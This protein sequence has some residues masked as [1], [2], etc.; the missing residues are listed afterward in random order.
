LIED[1]LRLLDKHIEERVAEHRSQRRW[2]IAR[3]IFTA[4]LLVST[5]A[6]MFL[7]GYQL[8]GAPVTGKTVGA[9]IKGDTPMQSNINETYRVDGYTFTFVDPDDLSIDGLW[10]YTFGEHSRQIYLQAGLPP[11]YLYST[12]VH[13]KLHTKGVGTENHDFIEEHEDR[14]VDETCLR[15]LYTIEQ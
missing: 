13:E 10:G 15:L 3:F 8:N 4:G 5:Y 11:K 2:E 12:C 6:F 14:I 1:R 9:T 7:V